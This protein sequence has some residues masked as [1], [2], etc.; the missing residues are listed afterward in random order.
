MIR[1]TGLL[2]EWDRTEIIYKIE[3][4]IF[5]P[6]V[7]SIYGLQVATSIACRAMLTRELLKKAVLA[8]MLAIL[9]A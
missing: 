9:H 6:V 2:G 7:Y 5:S 1:M 4:Q 3:E 8:S